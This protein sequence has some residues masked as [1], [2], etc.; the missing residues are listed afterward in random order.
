MTFNKHKFE[1]HIKDT[2]EKE[3]KKVLQKKAV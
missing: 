2:L 3:T 1:K